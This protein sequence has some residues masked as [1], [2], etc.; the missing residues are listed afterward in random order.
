MLIRFEN[1]IED[2]VAFN[3]FHHAYS[4]FLKRYMAGLRWGGALL[5]FGIVLLL[6]GVHLSPVNV[7]LGLVPAA[8][9]TVSLPPLIQ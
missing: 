8:I 6:L 5:I 7:I 9:Y 2:M 3:K 4:P 1:N